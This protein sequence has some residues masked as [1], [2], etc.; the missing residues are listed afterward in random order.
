MKSTFDEPRGARK[1]KPFK[2]AVL[3]CGAGGDTAG[4]EEALLEA[5]QEPEFTLINHWEV[6]TNTIGR[7]FPKARILTTG[8]DSVNPRTL[9]KEGELNFLW[10]SPECTHHSVARGGKPVKDQSRA[11]RK[12]IVWPNPTHGPV[13]SRDMFGSRQAWAT[14][15]DAVID[16]HLKGKSIFDRPVPHADN[17]LRRIIIGFLNGLD[18]ADLS[19]MTMGQQTDAAA[20]SVKEP[21]A[22]VSTAGAIALV[23][24]KLVKLRGTCKQTVP[25]NKPVP[26]VTTGRHIGLMQPSIVEVN[27]GR[28]SKT[29]D[30][31]VQ[32]T[33]Q[34]M[35]TITS[36]CGVGLAEYVV[37]TDQTGGNGAYS[38]PVGVPVGTVVTKANLALVEA[39]LKPYLVNNKG[40]SNDSPVDKLVPT[41]TAHARH[42]NL[43]Q[44]F[45]VPQF[46]SQGPRAVNRPMPTV[47]T[48]SRGVGLADPYLVPFHGERHKQEARSHSIKKPVPTV[49][50]SP[51]IGLSEPFVL[52][53]EGIHRGNAARSVRQ[54]MPTITS[55]GGGAL[56]QPQ[57]IKFYGTGGAKSVRLPLDTVTTKERFALV[58]FLITQVKK[59]NR[60]LLTVNGKPIGYLEILFR[61]FQWYELAL[62]QGFRPGYQFTG[63]V[64]QVV[65]QIGNAVPR[66][67]V[68]ALVKAAL[69][70]NPNVA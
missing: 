15:E 31:R 50:C 34:P 14:A 21:V 70:Q 38:N 68:R 6:A 57:V 61:M 39:S 59:K 37:Q 9:F 17:T 67:T 33:D 36:K 44:P 7:N 53:P 51:T 46:S 20:R 55:R 13:A 43:A 40:Q 23:E 10:A 69:T 26:A 4:T 11:S 48:Q 65:K 5:Q 56:I 29:E 47:T 42:L 28:N 18:K 30:H 64:E 32:S 16:W 1:R 2:A 27:H 54:P 66:R 63:N 45:I 35:A 62:A 41:V 52:P 24:P 8:I 12:K 60:P 49:P 22:T 25:V 58:E 3:F 19:A